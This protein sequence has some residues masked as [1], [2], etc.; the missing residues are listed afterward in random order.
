MKKISKL[1]SIFS[2]FIAPSIVS[3]SSSQSF[4]LANYES[5]ISDDLLSE[6]ENEF[7]SSNFNYRTYSTNEDLERNFLTNYDVAIPSLYLAA[8]YANEGKL[9]PIDWESFELHQLDENGIQK[10]EMIKNAKDALT[11]FTP[12][13]RNQLTAYWLED[14]Y[15]IDNIDEINQEAGLLNY[16]VPYFLQ[17]VSFGYNLSIEDKKIKELKWN[18]Y[19]NHISNLNNSLQSSW[20]EIIKYLYEKIN[21][22]SL[23]ERTAIVDD[24]STLYSI[25]R[26]MQT[27]NDETTVNPDYT[28]S[29][30]L[31]SYEGNLSIEESF[32]T[33]KYLFNFNQ[34]KRKN[35]I[36]L[37][38][39]SNTILN[40]FA[41]N[42]SQ[43]IISYNGDLLYAMQGGDDFSYTTNE[44]DFQEWMTKN[45]ITIKENETSKKRD[46]KL[47]LVKPDQ[48]LSVMDCMVINKELTTKK[49][50]VET[51]HEVIKKIGLEGS[52][53]SLYESSENKIYP[54]ER[55]LIFD[56]NEDDE[57]IYGPMLNFDYVNYTSP[58]LTI[59][60]YVMNSSSDLSKY[61]LEDS[62][63]SFSIE[64]Q[65]N[66]YFTELFSWINQTESKNG[67]LSEEEYNNYIE[68][69]INTY[70][71][72]EEKDY[73][74][75]INLLNKN[76]PDL[77][78]NNISWAWSSIKS[79][80]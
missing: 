19:I 18:D 8:K 34:I 67:F 24:Y 50:T 35:S 72:S 60:A 2:I 26:I 48:T 68:T 56:T 59:N 14:A 70:Y 12:Q 27:E 7:S 41:K 11:L 61:E 13:T 65:S 38:S 31:K 55:E 21:D 20:N 1:F 4:Y 49:G 66:G 32:D 62:Y 40:D 80:L 51:A 54:E 37:N 42:F 76:L 23:K 64:E 10:P 73:T 75:Y 29:G 79:N 46:F 22:G 71:I 25:A 57:Y 15:K 78:K 43:A 30:K 69:L 47:K 33:L 17:D 53:F 6:L 58:L 63:S 39:D 28:K 52:D 5:Y 45:L 3:C 44:K 36:L 16:C 77:V 9:L 74:K